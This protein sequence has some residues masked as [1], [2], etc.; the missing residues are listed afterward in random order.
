MEEGINL[1]ALKKDFF[2]AET[3]HSISH[4]FE[5]QS[6]LLPKCQWGDDTEY[7][8][9]GVAIAHSILQGGLGFCCL[10][11]ALYRY[12]ITQ[13]SEDYSCDVEALPCVVDIPR[14]V[15][16]KDLLDFI[17]KVSVCST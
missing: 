15:S 17:E 5:V 12:I 3:L 13:T 6:R 1:R 16:T 7:H 9:A 11:P 14:N 8:I 10:H 2:F 4:E